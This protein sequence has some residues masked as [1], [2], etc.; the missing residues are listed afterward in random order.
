MDVGAVPTLSEQEGEYA[1]L[2]VKE[3][4]NLLTRKPEGAL[5]TIFAI[6]ARVLTLQTI[7][8]TNRH[9]HTIGLRTFTSFLRNNLSGVLKTRT[10]SMGMTKLRGQAL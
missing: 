8:S 3:N 2:S 10:K 1:S 6:I 4:T 9:L 7:M 5:E